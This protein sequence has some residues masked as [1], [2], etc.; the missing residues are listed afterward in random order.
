VS[1]RVHEICEAKPRRAAYFAAIYRAIK[2]RYHVDSYRDVPQCQLQD[3]LQF[4][5]Q[6]EGGAHV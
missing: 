1:E 3:A 5:S 6:F 2:N 4:V